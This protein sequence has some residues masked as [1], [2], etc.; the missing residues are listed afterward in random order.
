[1]VWV[2]HSLDF[3]HLE[4]VD[5]RVTA[6]GGWRAQGIVA[7][8]QLD[9]L[10]THL[11]AVATAARVLGTR[12]LLILFGLAEGLEVAWGSCRIVSRCSPCIIG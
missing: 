9:D 11:V 6:L 5:C 7:L 12:R 2:G 3:T 4:A 1:M 8:K 10:L